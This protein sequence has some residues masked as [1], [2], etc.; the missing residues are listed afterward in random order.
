MGA[1][2]FRSAS[3]PGHGREWR[4]LLLVSAPIGARGV[5][6][7]AVRDRLLQSGVLHF[8]GDVELAAVGR[9]LVGAGGAAAATSL[10]DGHKLIALP[11]SG[12]GTLISARA[13]VGRI[14]R[15]ARIARVGGLRRIIARINGEH[16]AG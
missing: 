8:G 5:V 10:S 2:R 4:T 3:G 16:A 12:R 6:Y 14:V 15:V 11:L 13:V 1:P 7:E 9:Q